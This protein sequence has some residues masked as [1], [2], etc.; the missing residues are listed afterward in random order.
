VASFLSKS[1]VTARRG[2][3][4]GSQP[5]NGQVANGQATMQITVRR[6][7]GYAGGTEVANIDTSNLEAGRAREIERL[8]DEAAAAAPQAEAVGADLIRYEIT[9]KDD[10]KTQ[11]LTFV[12]IGTTDGGPLKRL[13]EKLGG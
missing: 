8:V 4:A 10:G 3:R 2:D 1:G 7:G 13:I 11:V 6:T 9:I 12:D 5:T